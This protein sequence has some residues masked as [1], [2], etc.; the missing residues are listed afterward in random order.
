MT[1]GNDSE[2]RDVNKTSDRNLFAMK[3]LTMTMHLRWKY[4]PET[5]VT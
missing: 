3:A 2:K 1:Q 5:S 4:W